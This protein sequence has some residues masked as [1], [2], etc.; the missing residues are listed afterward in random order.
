[1]KQSTK[2]G[3]VS[4]CIAAAVML[5]GCKLPQQVKDSN[6]GGQGVATLKIHAAP[7]SPFQQIVRTAVLEISASDMLPMTNSLTITDSSVEGLIKGIPAG[8]A[9]LFQVYVYDSMEVMQYMG[10]ATADVIADSTVHVAISIVRIGGNAI[11]NGTV[12]DSITDTSTLTQGLMAYYPF[13]GNANDAS[14]NGF[15]GTVSSSATLTTDRFGNANK[16]YFFNG[17]GGIV[18]TV[19]TLLS[20]SKF[21]IAAWIKSNGIEAS[22]V[23]RIAS[24]TRPGQCNGYYE[25]LYANGNWTGSSNDYSKKLICYLNADPT[26]S[27]YNLYY[28][29][30]P[31]DTSTWHHGAIT[32]DSGTLKFYID[33]VLDNT[34]SAL[35]PLTQFAESAVLQIGYCEGGGNFNGKIDEVRIYNRALSD[36]EILKLFTLSN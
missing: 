26:F 33:G 25:L 6:T 13:N 17:S 29:Q 12:N 7:N 2:S 9:R 32:F 11:I 8:K 19:N 28:S 36:A 30:N 10:S 23:P 31:A 21:T 18:T 35:G 15:N 24:I 14:G 5:F 3:M 1:M 16:A 27:Y 34:I 20:V 22:G 4:A